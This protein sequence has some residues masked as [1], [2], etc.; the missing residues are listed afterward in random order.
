MTRHHPFRFY[1]RNGIYYVVFDRAPDSPR[2][3][4][5]RVHPGDCRNSGT[6]YDQAVSWAYAHQQTLTGQRLTLREATDRMFTASCPWRKRVTAKGHR[7]SSVYFSRHRKRMQDYIWPRFGELAPDKIRP[8][9]ID[10]WLLSLDSRT[11]GLPMSPA[12]KDKII[13]TLR[14]VYDELVYQ[15][16]A[17]SSPARL[18]S[19]FHDS[20]QRRAPILMSEFSSLFPTDQD[21]MERIWQGLSWATFFYIMGTTGMRPGEVAAMDLAYWQKGIGYACCQAIDPDTR[22]VKGLKT[23]KKGVTVKPVYLNERAESLITQLVFQSGYSGGL[24]FPGRKGRGRSPEASNTRF[25]ASCSR[26][27]IDL[28]GRTQYSLRH[29]YATTMAIEL[30]EAEAAKYLGQRTFRDDYDHREAMDHLRKDD[31]MREL[32][33]RLFG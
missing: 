10:D 7:F 16:L 26:A 33:N 31:R 1:R 20:E 15:G 3:T 8:V 21:E 25:K 9:M 19:Y 17:D 30:S 6:G 2:S 12:M 5:V 29:F 28:A 4:G 18:V 23:E 32:S 27:G 24:L 14:K 13:Q 22:E 11:T